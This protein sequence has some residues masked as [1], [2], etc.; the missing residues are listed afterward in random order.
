[1]ENNILNREHSSDV[2]D[3]KLKKLICQH[4]NPFCDYVDYAVVVQIK[5]GDFS[6]ELFNAAIC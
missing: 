2:D 5:I 6:G 3:K 4:L 1:M